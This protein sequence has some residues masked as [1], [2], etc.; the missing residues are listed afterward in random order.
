[1]VKILKKAA[2]PF[3]IICE[4][5][6]PYH[7]ALVGAL[8]GEG[9][10]VS[11]INPR[12]IRDFARASGTLA[13]TDKIDARILADFGAKMQPSPTPP[14]D[15]VN[16]E[17]AVLAARR[18]DLV[19]ARSNEAKRLSQT[20][21]PF[22]VASIKAHIEHLN[23]QITRCEQE[24]DEL[25]AGSERLQKQVKHL[26]EVKGVGRLSATLLLA[27][28]PELGTLSKNQITALA[29]LAPVCRDSGKYRGKRTIYGGRLTMRTALYMAAVS[30]SRFNPVLSAF[31]KKLIDCGKPFKV[32][33]TAVMR[34]LLI[35]LNSIAKRALDAPLQPKAQALPCSP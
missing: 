22:C 15:P 26:S 21:H 34:K 7:K 28:A 14:P 8:H 31:Y 9:I 27:A 2:R 10:L 30:A 4:A 33:I 23:E 29:G 25:L 32:A 18:H 11:V 3:H 19:E 1:L 12:Q 20:E 16:E 13:K 24:I 5:T 6:G 35:A 17:L